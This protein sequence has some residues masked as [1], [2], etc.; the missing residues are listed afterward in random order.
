LPFGVRQI[1]SVSHPQLI[2]VRAVK[3]KLTLKPGF[4]EF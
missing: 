2:E 4:P 3:Y 1:R